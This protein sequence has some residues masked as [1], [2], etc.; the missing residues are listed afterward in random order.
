MTSIL[1]FLD[2]LVK[3]CATCHRALTPRR[4]SDS[5]QTTIIRRMLESRDEVKNFVNSM[6]SDP[7]IDAVAFVHQSLK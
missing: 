4:A 2:N 7:K 1:A 5:L 6:I 3:L